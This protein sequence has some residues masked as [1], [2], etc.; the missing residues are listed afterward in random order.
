MQHDP[1]PYQ[2]PGGVVAPEG[3]YG[4]HP[5]EVQRLQGNLR[6]LGGIQIAFGLIGSLGVL[7]SGALLTSMNTNPVQREMNELFHRG[8]IGTWMEISRWVGLL[9]GV[10]LLS[11]G[12]SLYRMRPIGRP[13]SLL[14]ASL[15]TVLVFVGLYMNLAYVFP[16]L[17]DFAQHGGPIAK[18]GARGGVMGGLMGSIIGLVLPAFELYFMTRP[19]TRQALGIDPPG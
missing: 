16:A 13:L 14:H 1:N 11:A 9:A 17:E 19:A 7:A 3:G 6:I 2:P 15:A 18:A 8:T 10:T 5:Y 12:I 4:V